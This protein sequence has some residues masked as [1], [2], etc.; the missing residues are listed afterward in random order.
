ML[1]CLLKEIEKYGRNE[2]RLLYCV[3]MA[4]KRDEGQNGLLS[5]IHSMRGQAS[6]T[7]EGRVQEGGGPWE[8][9]TAKWE[10]ESKQS[11]GRKGNVMP[12]AV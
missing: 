8:G 9:K 10:I 1:G 12:E 7:R 6:H 5:I 2:K 4:K 11:E 3:Y